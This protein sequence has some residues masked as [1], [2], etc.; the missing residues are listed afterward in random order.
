MVRGHI[1]NI[2][3]F[4][5]HDGP[6]IRTTVFLKG[7]PLRCLWCHNPEGIAPGPQ[8][9]L[10]PRRCIECGECVPVCPQGLPTPGVPAELKD[11]EACLAC[12]AC[13]EACPCKARQLAG[14]EVS[15]SE[16]LDEVLK[17]RVFFEESAGG[18]T[19]SGGEPLWQPEFLRGLLQACR[20]QGIHTV[21]DTCGMAPW[22]D[23]EAVAE[24]TDLFLFDV[25]HMEDEAHRRLTGVSNRQIL[26][27]LRR[28]G[29]TH[30]RI[31]VR[32]PVLAQVNDSAEN[33]QAT[34]E[35]AAGLEGVEKVCLLPYHP[36]GEDKLRR[37]GRPEELEGVTRPTEGQLKA[38]GSLVEATGVSTLVGG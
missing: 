4:S 1:F 15:V 32:V 17:D 26:A 5:V 23:L 36:L 28:L 2:Q 12:G 10:S 3:R 9:V 21:V 38:W 22:S 20:D 27:N 14:T 31:W 16:V 29:K 11:L 13:V 33:L 18:V 6:G 34:G 19:F 7:C 37:M 25:K 24:E 8:L 30:R 35:L